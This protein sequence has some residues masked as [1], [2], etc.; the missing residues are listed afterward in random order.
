M[1]AGLDPLPRD[2]ASNGQRPIPKACAFRT[3]GRSTSIGP[4]VVV[5]VRGLEAVAIDSGARASPRSPAWRSGRDPERAGRRRVD[6]RAPVVP[7][8][9]VAGARALVDHF[10]QQLG[11]RGGGRSDSSRGPPL[12]LS[13]RL[14][15]A[16]PHARSSRNA[17]ARSVPTRTLRCCAA[18]PVGRAFS[19]P[20]GPLD[21][22]GRC[23][24]PLASRLE[25]THEGVVARE[26]PD[27]VGVRVRDMVL[28]V[29]DQLVVAVAFQTG[30]PVRAA[31]RLA[32]AVG[33]VA[34][35]RTQRRRARNFAQANPNPTRSAGPRDPSVSSMGMPPTWAVG[36]LI[37]GRSR[38]CSPRP[39]AGPRGLAR[40]R[41]GGRGSRR[42]SRGRSPCRPGA[43]S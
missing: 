43:R 21:V 20:D 25:G 38:L 13:E 10:S 42:R 40:D 15:G 3:P 8:D 35:E 32:R 2:P 23:H 29:R 33:S 24:A 22:G 41:R 9:A 14:A 36:T 31:P 7:R 26:L 4:L 1:R 12:V 18:F 11:Q 34:R 6:A 30:P 37:I 5:T 39:G 19:C 17:G 28:R 27:Q 16:G